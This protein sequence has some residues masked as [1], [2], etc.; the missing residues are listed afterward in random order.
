MI[1]ADFWELPE[2]S[3][4]LKGGPTEHF[5][6]LKYHN[7]LGF[8]W[9]IFAMDEPYIVNLT[10]ARRTYGPGLKGFNNI[11]NFNDCLAIIM[12]ISGLWCGDNLEQCTSMWCNQYPEHCHERDR[13]RHFN[14]VHSEWIMYGWRGAVFE[15][16]R[17]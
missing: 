9:D 7:Q 16:I 2:V 4:E 12:E 8:Y 11:R 10:E 17:R 5:L 14:V 6:R 13:L 15:Y 1:G 3:S